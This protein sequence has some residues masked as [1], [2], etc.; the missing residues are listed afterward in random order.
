M[1]RRGEVGAFRMNVECLVE[2]RDLVGESPLWHP[3]H[4]CVYWTDINGFKVNRYSAKTRELKCWR[5]D[6]PVT[7]LSLTTV[8]EWL[9]VAVGGGLILWSP[10][11]DRRIRSPSRSAIGLITD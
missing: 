2:A 11:T 1:S 10:E 6:G 9:L 7:T 8:A 3:E 4:G 5:F